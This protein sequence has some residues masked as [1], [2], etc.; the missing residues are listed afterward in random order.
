VSAE[1]ARARCKVQVDIG[2]GDAV[3]PG[4]VHATYPV[5]LADFAAPQL[6]T[7]PV[8]TVLAEKLH[9]SVLATAIA[10]TFKRRSTAVPTT[11][12]IG[13]SDEFANDA[14]RQA[15]W[16]AF[17]KKNGLAAVA[18]AALLDGA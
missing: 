15:L 7:Y 10:A 2:F 8:Y 16:A 3:T 1:L 5:L 17:L 14:S 11:L 6:R 13:L 12:P 4:P 18:Q 9:A